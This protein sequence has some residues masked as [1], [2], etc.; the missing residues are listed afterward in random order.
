LLG[1]F[2]FVLLNDDRGGRGGSNG[3]AGDMC[4]LGELCGGGLA[5]AAMAAP[6]PTVDDCGAA[7]DDDEEAVV[8]VASLME[9]RARARPL[10]S[11]TVSEG[12]SGNGDTE[13]ADWLGDTNDD[14][15]R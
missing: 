6:P 2:G 3:A 13:R 15:E 8:G 7:D 10:E 5:S 12:G 9:R 14:D 1:V 11:N 4:L